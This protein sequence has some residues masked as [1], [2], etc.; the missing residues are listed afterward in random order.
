MENDSNLEVTKSKDDRI[1]KII[2]SIGLTLCCLVFGSLSASI[3]YLNSLAIQNESAIAT[4][5]VYATATSISHATK[6]AGY[7]IFDD[8]DSNPHHWYVDEEDEKNNDRWAGTIAIR[9]GMYVWDIR[10]VKNPGSLS[11]RDYDDQ[12]I[13]QDFDLSID[14]K[15]VE[16]SP[17]LLCYGIAFRVSPRSFNSG[18]YI[19]SICDNGVYSLVNH[20]KVDGSEILI[21]WTRSVDIHSG[22]WNSLSV[23]ARGDHIVLSINNVNV[24]EFVDAHVKGGYIYLVLRIFGDQPG[25]IFFDNFAFQPSSK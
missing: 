11:W 5:Q 12:K 4:A 7:E 25:T 10:E 3:Y 13:V 9:D 1:I 22:E 14:A 2:T 24:S 8:F 23:N 6:V 15:L 21:P 19:F 16:G 20:N 18:G 17:E